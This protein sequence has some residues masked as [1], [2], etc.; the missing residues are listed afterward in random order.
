MVEGLLVFFGRL[1]DLRSDNSDFGRREL[2]I[3]QVTNDFEDFAASWKH[4][5][6]SSLV[7]VHRVH[8]LYFLLAIVAF[9]GSRVDL[10]PALDFFATFRSGLR[11]LRSGV[12]SFATISLRP[13]IDGDLL[14]ACLRL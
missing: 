14:F 11:S 12:F 1:I 13:T 6:A 5:T 8:E 2:H 10:T 9:A 7:F 4:P 3:A